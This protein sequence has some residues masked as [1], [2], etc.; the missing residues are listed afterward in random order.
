MEVFRGLWTPIWTLG[1][2]AQTIYNWEQGK[3]KPRAEQFASLVAVRDFGQREA[4]KRLE[5]L[6][7]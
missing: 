5:L 1:V 4:L 2:T 6:E 3:S 7:G